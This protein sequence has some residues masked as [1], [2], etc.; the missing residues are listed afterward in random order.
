MK[1]IYNGLEIECISFGENDLAADYLWHISG[2]SVGA[3]TYYT[4]DAFN[5]P[6]PLGQCWYDGN[7]DNLDFDWASP[8]GG[9][10]PGSQ[11]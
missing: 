8:R 6:V 1:K 11:P 5:N 2:C 10:S 7:P 9:V 3:S 4:S